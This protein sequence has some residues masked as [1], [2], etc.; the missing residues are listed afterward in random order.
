M[1]AIAFELAL[2]E[3]GIV[4]RDCV[5]SISRSAAAG[6][7]HNRAPIKSRHD[8]RPS[9]LDANLSRVILIAMSID[10]NYCFVA[11]VRAGCEHQPAFSPAAPVMVVTNDCRFVPDQPQQ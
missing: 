8:W 2:C 10:L 11:C 3:F 5:R 9:K 4:E 7:R 1:P 6:L